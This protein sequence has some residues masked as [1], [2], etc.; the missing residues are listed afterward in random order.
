MIASAVQ[1]EGGERAE[2]NQSCARGAHRGQQP[3]YRAEQDDPPDREPDLAP[4]DRVV[5]ASLEGEEDDERER[6]HRARE[7]GT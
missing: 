1:G 4:H 2:P 6:E 5:A 3:D 7:P